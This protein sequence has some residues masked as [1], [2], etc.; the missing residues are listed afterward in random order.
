MDIKSPLS[1]ATT[2]TSVHWI[3]GEHYQLT[4]FAAAAQLALAP[5]APSTVPS[6]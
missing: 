1:L 5:A 2:A 6:S 3:N 4:E